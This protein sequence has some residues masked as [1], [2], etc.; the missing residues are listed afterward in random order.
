[1]LAEMALKLQSEKSGTIRE[2]NQALD[3]RS[4]ITRSTIYENAPFC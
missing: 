1:M 2:F 4:L 3:V